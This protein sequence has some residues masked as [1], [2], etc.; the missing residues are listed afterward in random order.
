MTTPSSMRWPSCVA[1]GCTGLDR[2]VPNAV[3]LRSMRD[4]ERTL[5][6][7]IA[8]S[9]VL[10]IVMGGARC[11]PPDPPETKPFANRCENSISAQPDL[12]GLSMDF[13][14]NV[15]TTRQQGVIA[16]RYAATENCEVKLEVLPNCVGR[17][18]YS[19]SPYPGNESKLAS[20][21]LELFAKLP[22]GAAALEGKLAKGRTLRT[23]YQFAGLLTLPLGQAYDR[24]ALQGGDECEGAT[25]IVNRI[26]VGGFALAVGETLAITAAAT[27]FGVGAGGG[28]D[29]SAELISSEGLRDHCIKAQEAGE[30]STQC[31]APLRLGLLALSG[32]SGDELEA[33]TAG[34]VP[35]F[36]GEQSKCNADTE[37]WNGTRC[38]AIARPTRLEDLYFRDEHGCKLGLQTWFNGACVENEGHEI[39]DS[40][41]LNSEGSPK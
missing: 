2:A 1:M 12:M 11:G 5:A 17:G 20:N 26:Y 25:H 10:S 16:V 27:I 7:R 4:H 13:R 9:V 18:T 30:L 6:R 28:H 35:L 8:V 19:F 33:D 15:A 31:Q 3:C 24:D 40:L 21:K 37:V 39:Y 14:A 32:A 23:D 34:F 41:K 36:T 38:E 22:L 29:A